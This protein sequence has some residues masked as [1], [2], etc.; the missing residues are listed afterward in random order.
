MGPDGRDPRGD[1]REAPRPRRRRV[2][3][4]P[5]VERRRRAAGAAA[6]RRLQRRRVRAGHLQGPGAHGERSVRRRRGAHDRRV[7][8]RLRARLPLHP[9]RVPAGAERARRTRS[10]RRARP[11][12]SATTSW[13][14]GFAFD[15]ELRRGAGA[16]ICGEETAL[17]NS[18]EGKRGE[19]RNK[20]PFPV[21]AGLFG[22]PTVVNNV[23]TPAQ[24]ARHPARRRRRRSPR[25]A[26]S[27]RP[28]R[29]CSACPGC[30]ERP[31][32]YEAP[33]GVTLRQVLEMAGGV[34]DGTTSRRCCWAARRAASSARTMLDLELTFEATRAAGA[35]LGSGVMLVFDETV[36]LVPILLRIAAL[37]PRRVLRA[38]RALPCRHGSPAGGALAPRVA[39]AARQRGRRDSRCWP[40]SR[41]R[42]VTRPSAASG[43]LPP[44]RSIPPSTAF[45]CSSPREPE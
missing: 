12:C 39:P 17:F 38:V 15:I 16:Y 45:A 34:R 23:E 1:R 26:P 8:H 22:K 29:G 6:L 18:I 44:T 27:S 4:R 30:V 24:R 37:L 14:R 13:A 20:P 19:P 28:A 33:F 7:R 41:R 10:T 21:D 9:R 25:S 36:D 11:A 40:R 31:G 32:V 35:T 2:P 42:C 43:R 3:D 5:Q